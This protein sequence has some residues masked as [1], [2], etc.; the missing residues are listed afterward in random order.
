MKASCMHD[1]SLECQ[2]KEQKSGVKKR[3]KKPKAP[4]KITQRYLHNAGLA[5]LQRFATSSAHFKT[6]MMRKID[7][8]C[9]HHKEQNKEDCEALLDEL[10]PKFQDLGLLDDELFIRGTVISSRRK[11]LSS[12]KIKQKLMQKGIAIDVI[13]NAI[14]THDT[15]EYEEYQNDDYING[16]I[17][18]AVTFIRRKKLG[19]FDLDNKKIHEKSLA[20]MARAGFSYQIANKILLMDMEQLEEEFID[21]L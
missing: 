4:R 10:I 11:G 20:K 17:I 18:A 16:D 14:K 2:N 7:K 12:M 8:S 19:A 13:D 9:L 15:N 6:I 21:L 5:Y 3:Q 1:T